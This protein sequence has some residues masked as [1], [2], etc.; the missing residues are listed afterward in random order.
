M[1]A[2]C[3]ETRFFH[4]INHGIEEEVIKGLDSAARDLFAVPSEAKENVSVSSSY[5]YFKRTDSLYVESVNFK[6]VV[7]SDPAQRISDCLW[8]DGSP[9]FW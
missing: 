1:R 3:Q 6:N 8:P 9:T 4:V 5:D 2:A 7:L